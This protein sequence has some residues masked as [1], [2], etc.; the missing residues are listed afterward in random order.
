MLGGFFLGDWQQCL[1]IVGCVVQ[2]IEVVDQEVMY[3]EVVVIEQCICY[4]F[5]GVYQCGGVMFVVYQLGDVGL[6]VFVYYFVLC[7]GSLQLL[8]VDFVWFGFEF[9]FVLCCLFGG[10]VQDMFGFFSGFGFVVGDNW[11]E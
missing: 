1:V 4:L 11:L 8:G 5:W 6:Q 9:V 10:D 3:F 2:W 7:C